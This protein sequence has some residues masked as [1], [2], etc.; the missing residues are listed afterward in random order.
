MLAGLGLSLAGDVALLWSQQGF[1]PG[2][3][4]FLGAHLAYLVAFTRGVRLGVSP[5]AYAGYALLACGVL[6]VLWPGV[7]AG[8]RVPVAAYV[9]CL[10]AVAAQTP[11]PGGCSHINSFHSRRPWAS[12]TLSSCSPRTSPACSGTSIGAAT[13]VP[14]PLGV[15]RFLG[16]AASRS[17]P[18]GRTKCPA[19]SSSRNALAQPAFCVAPRLSR[20]PKS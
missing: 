17:C 20:K 3:G 7:P 13:A 11:A 9:L 15:R 16:R 12:S 1:L 14:R 4:A 6:A 18:A 5:T 2:L 19:R 10:A 8:L